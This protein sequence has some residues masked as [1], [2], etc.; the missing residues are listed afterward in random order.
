MDAA[1][2]G[3]AGAASA[4][5]AEP[6]RAPSGGIESADYAMECGVF[7][8]ASAVARGHAAAT[9]DALTLF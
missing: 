6:G 5:T 8:P 1:P 4:T 2:Q 9:R 7:C 3:A